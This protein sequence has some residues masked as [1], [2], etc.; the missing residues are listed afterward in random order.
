MYTNGAQQSAS[1]AAFSGDEWSIPRFRAKIPHFTSKTVEHSRYLLTG[2]FGQE[3]AGF[4]AKHEHLVPRV[5][6]TP[7]RR[8]KNRER[9][10]LL[11]TVFGNADSAFWPHSG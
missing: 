9:G 5:S 3:Q 6:S 4:S 8:L 10:G 2:K 1:L 11:R 7:I